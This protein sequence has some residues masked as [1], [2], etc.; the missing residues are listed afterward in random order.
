MTYS[1]INNQKP[2]ILNVNRSSDKVNLIVRGQGIVVFKANQRCS[3]NFI[4]KYDKLGLKV[5]FTNEFIIV[6]MKP[7]NEPL[8]DSK[9]CKG[10]T[11][12]EGAYY[13]FSLDSQNLRLYAGIGET[14][15]ENIIYSYTF[16]NKNN[17]DYKSFLES[18][19]SI[20]CDDLDII[21][22]VRDPITSSIPLL[23]K[24]TEDLTMDD[25]AKGTYMP[26]A[27]LSIM[28]QK[29]YDCIAGNKFVLNT[30]DFPDFMKA[31]EYSIATP[32]KW[33]YECLKKKANE[34]DKDKPN[35]K[36]TYLRITLGQNN[37]ESPGIPYVMEI[38]PVGH[39]SPIHNH[40]E[41]SAIIRVLNGSINIS[42]FPYLSS[43]NVA[44][45]A[46][47]DFKKDDI[48]WI[49]PTL[50]QVHQLKNLEKNK[51][52]CVTIQ[53]YMYE[54]E[55]TEHY[56]YF[57]YIDADNKIEQFEPNSDMDFVL[58]KQTI[59]KEWN[60]RKIAWFCF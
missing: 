18:L 44:P 23:V 27:N 17:K 50:N 51:D 54:N 26:K 35:D 34:F 31:I 15:E 12:N 58:F 2:K 38:W 33:C 13:W 8:I 29:L 22:L 53:C 16:S 52:T 45:F 1:S 42:L 10:L 49:S 37:G 7:S 24:N 3:L 11:K 46:I 30:H 25:I 43:D 9:N 55:N 6:T 56:D 41:S 20:H 39:Y 5:Q 59:R 57:D 21:R 28:S 60:E 14:R 48:T 47:A 36:K 40:G 32:G 19:V 4:N